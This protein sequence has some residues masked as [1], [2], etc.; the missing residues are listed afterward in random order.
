MSNISSCTAPVLHGLFRD[1]CADLFERQE[2]ANLFCGHILTLPRAENVI[3]M[4]HWAAR[5]GQLTTTWKKKSGQLR[6]KAAWVDGFRLLCLSKHQVSLTPEDR[7]VLGVRA[8]TK[9]APAV[10]MKFNHDPAG[11]PKAA[12][13]DMCGTDEVPFVHLCAWISTN[14]LSVFSSKNQ[15][16]FSARRW[17]VWQETRSE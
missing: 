13:G 9:K 3:E 11:C 17:P 2:K 8:V 7:S 12:A 14:T 10:C 5:T 1:I 4:G 15:H 16:T 6:V